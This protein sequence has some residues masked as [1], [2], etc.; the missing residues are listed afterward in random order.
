MT[1]YLELL[2]VVEAIAA[3]DMTRESMIEM[4]REA[5]GEVKPGGGLIPHGPLNDEPDDEE[6]DEED[7]PTPSDD[8]PDI[9]AVCRMNRAGGRVCKCMHPDER[10]EV[11]SLTCAACTDPTNGRY[12]GDCTAEVFGV[13]DCRAEVVTVAC[14]NCERPENADG[15][16]EWCAASHCTECGEEIPPKTDAAGKPI[17]VGAMA[18]FT[19]EPPERS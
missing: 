2:G 16:C 11:D 13:A 12:P 7:R 6:P 5:L 4:A 3:G 17:S 8:E 10:E 19:G 18:E 9:C 1:E 15:I 14:A